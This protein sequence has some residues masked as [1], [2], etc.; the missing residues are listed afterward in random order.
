MDRDLT[1]GPDDRMRIDRRKL[2]IAPS[3]DRV[4]I[5]RPDRPRGTL[6]AMPTTS[7]AEPTACCVCGLPRATR[8]VDA[9]P[10][11]VRE[12]LR[13]EAPPAGSEV[14]VA[15]L[16]E[17]RLGHARATFAHDRGARPEAER[18]PS[19]SEGR[20][21]A[22]EQRTLATRLGVE[23]DELAVALADRIEH[24]PPPTLG[25]RAA[26][27]VASVGGS[28][29]FVLGFSG[30]L[31]VWCLVN[32]VLL[33]TRAFDPF[34]FVFLNL[35]LSCLAALQ[36]PIIMMSQARMGEVDRVRAMEDFRINL[37]AELEVASVH[38]KLDHLLHQQW[39]RMLELQ[40]LQLEIL[41]QLREPDAR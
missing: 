8:A 20:S 26:D 34:P 1:I 23:A 36:A 11:V 6:P 10:T 21:G 31:V 5:D 2:P 25:Q 22:S 12:H 16:I 17:A 38:E 37:K 14:C 13:V 9:L 28:W 41:S 4:G 18:A 3:D 39:D 29:R 40:E 27:R 24:G 33:A 15:C 32:G 30:F 7:R 19:L 35:L